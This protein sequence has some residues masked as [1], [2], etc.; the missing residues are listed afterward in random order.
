M[1][2]NGMTSNNNNTNNNNN[3]N[4]LIYTAP[5]AKLQRPWA[6]SSVNSRL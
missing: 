3:N 4:N 6:E 2:V 5:C 1:S